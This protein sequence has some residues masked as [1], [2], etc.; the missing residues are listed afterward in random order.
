MGELRLFSQPSLLLLLWLAAFTL[1]MAYAASRAV[2]DGLVDEAAGFITELF[3]PGV[4]LR[5]RL[6]AHGPLSLPQAWWT[7]SL[8]PVAMQEC[9]VPLS[10]HCMMQPPTLQPY[11]LM[12]EAVACAGRR[13]VLCLAA[14]IGVCTF[15]A[16]GGGFVLRLSTTAAA[17]GGFLLFKFHQQ[18]LHLD[19]PD[20]D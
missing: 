7:C 17:V 15:G 11:L 5:A 9:H 20:N 10:T 18:R 16:M 8:W 14:G 4:P 13:P 1:P 6:V 3:E 12:C 2:L 19:P